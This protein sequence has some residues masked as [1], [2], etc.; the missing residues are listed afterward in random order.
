MYADLVFKFAYALVLHYIHVCLEDADLLVRVG[1]LNVHILGR[2]I[3][4]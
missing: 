2:S 4:G 3:S 1:S